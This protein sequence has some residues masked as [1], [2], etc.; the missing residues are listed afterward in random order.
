MEALQKFPLN[1]FYNEQEL[2]PNLNKLIEDKS[3]IYFNNYYQ[4][5]GRG[6]TAD[7]EF[8]S[9]NSLYPSMDEPTYSQYE[10]NTF[11]GL[12]WVLR[13]N[14]YRSWVFH[15]YKKEFWNRERAYPN[16]GFERFIS[17]EDY[18]LEETIGFGITDEEFFKQSM[19]YLKEMGGS[20]PC[21]YDK[22]N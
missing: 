15:G 20:I 13:D 18:N 19:D 17:E 7:A 1:R 2:T 14:G 21:L 11:H 5:I 8:V 4:Q 12:P 22:F 10:E 16:Q 6:N 9:N 3:T